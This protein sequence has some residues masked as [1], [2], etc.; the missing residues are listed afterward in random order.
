SIPNDRCPGHAFQDAR[1][2]DATG[3]LRA[4]VPRGGTD[5]RGAD[6]NGGGVAA[7]GIKAS[8]R[9]E[10]GRAGARPPCRPPDALQRAAGLARSAD[11][12]DEGDGRVL[13][14]K[15]RRPR[16]PAAKDGPM[17]DRATE[18]RSVAVE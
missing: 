12:L 11:R 1:R 14:E 6:G 16:R 3:D 10:A 17:N 15:I 2:P 8:R 4:A 9:A 18:T 13:G 7:G 5:G